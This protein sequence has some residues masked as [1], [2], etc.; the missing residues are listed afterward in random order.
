MCYVDVVVTIGGAELC[1]VKRCDGKGDENV[2]MGGEVGSYH[3]QNVREAKQSTR[4]DGD[5]IVDFLFAGPSKPN[6]S[7]YPTPITNE[8]NLPKQRDR[9][10]DATQ[11]SRIQPLLQGHCLSQSQSLH[12][13]LLV[14]QFVEES[15]D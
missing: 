14:C 11:L 13:C 6:Q 7:Q 10:S 2:G 3:V 9:K 15:N 12:S 5:N 1:C 8:N 4:E